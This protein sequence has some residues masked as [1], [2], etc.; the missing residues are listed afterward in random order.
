MILQSLCQT[1]SFSLTTPEI[2]NYK[3]HNTNPVNIKSGHGGQEG[4]FR[5][6]R[7]TDFGMSGPSFGVEYPEPLVFHHPR[8]GRKGPKRIQGPGRCRKPQRE[9]WVYLAVRD[10]PGAVFYGKFTPKPVMTRPKNPLP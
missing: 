3:S 1:P 9:G 10:E 7:Y 6:S 2:R 8:A 4:V 5:A